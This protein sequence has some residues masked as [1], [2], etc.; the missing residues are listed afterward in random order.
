[1]VT[2]AAAGIPLL[3][4]P[5]DGP[6]LTC[7][8]PIYRKDRRPVHLLDADWPIPADPDAARLGL[9]RW[10]DRMA[11]CDDR[12]LADFCTGLV[13]SPAGRAMLEAVF[14]NS[15]FLTE[16]LL[17]NAAFCRAL[18]ETGPDDATAAVIAA[19]VDLCADETDRARL[20]SALRRAKQKI[21][22]ATALA[23]VAGTWPLDRVCGTLTSFAETAVQ[24]AARHLLRASAA[25]G[26]LSLPHPDDPEAESGLIV[27]GMGKLGA[28]ELNYSSDIDLIV[29]YDE[30]RAPVRKADRLAQTFV[31]LARDLTGIMEER[32]GDGYIFRT[33]LRLRPDPGATPPAVSVGG[34]EAYYGSMAQNWE[35]AAMI[36]ARPIAGDPDAGAAFVRFLRQFVWRRDLDFAAIADIHDIKRQIHRHKGHAAIAIN[37]H[38]I[39][40]GRGGIREI[41]FFAQTQQLIFGGREPRLRTP[42]TVDALAALADTGRI[43]RETADTLTASYRELR[44]IEHRLQMIGDQQTHTLPEDDAGLARLSTFLGYPD[45]DMFRSCLGRTLHDVEDRYAE[46]FEGSPVL[47]DAGGLVFGGAEDNP[48][49]LARLAELGFEDPPA[50]AGA[51]RGWLHGRYRALRSERSRRLLSDILPVL[52]R[53]LA[54]TASPDTALRRLDEFLSRLP[55]GVQLFSMFHANPT[56]LDL[57]AELMGTSRRLADHLAQSPAQLDSVLT[58]GFMEPLPG[59]EALADDLGRL[60]GTTDDYEDVLN[61]LRRW[62]NDQRFRAGVHLLR[63]LAT[64]EAYGR[65]LSSVAEVGLAGLV[66]RVE[67][68][69][70]RR[71]GRFAG[72]GDQG[73]AVVA[74]GKLGGREM[75]IRSDLDLIIVYAADDPTSQ[76]DGEK[77]LSATLY[78]T[79][80]IQRLLSAITAPTR[81][82]ALYDVDMRLRPSGN[83]GPLATSLEAFNRYQAESAWTWE[84]MALTRARVIAGPPGVRRKLE[85]VICDTLCRPRDEAALLRDVADMRRRIDA[86]HGTDQIWSV[87]YARGGLVDIEFIAQ[88]L[89]LRHAHSH[90]QV[91]ATNTAEAIGRLAAAGILAP[92]RARRLV[93]TLA[94]WQRVQSYLRLAVDA[95]FSPEEAPAPLLD[96]LARAALC[97]GAK[98][99]AFADVEARVR[100]AADWVH[101]E[102]DR[103]IDTPAAA[104]GPAGRSA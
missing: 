24:M 42:R 76:S 68:E 60:L 7:P 23:D 66:P 17:A 10:N 89:Q 8:A 34:A 77:P 70:A 61:V 56:L 81:E 73:M 96:G 6:A 21:A 72:G 91:L 93:D 49:T 92:D 13:E 87:K 65:F 50:V 79:R 67:A 86:E 62:T 40:L 25:N 101:A 29:L 64:A 4:A 80:L 43:D 88:Y 9:E 55:A 16:A 98:D 78:Y 33:D 54:A 44:R 20:M 74:M 5:M 26:V 28:T 22:I 37:G 47:P 82:G 52:M 83:A 27:L 100:A 99:L 39:K 90:R 18:L 51:V 103:L 46:L 57:V 41:E 63:R 31:R 94:M 3:S 36:K 84:H 1:M 32:T 15:P 85:A 71:H 12:G 58:P 97:D 19:A 104:L 48:D 75:A 30:V 45:A 35:R 38:N 11:V 59:T 53:A 2:G 95:A 14:G 102:Y 69:F